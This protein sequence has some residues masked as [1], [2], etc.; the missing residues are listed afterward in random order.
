[1]S[2]GSLEIGSR[3]DACLAQA[4]AANPALTDVA[5]VIAACAEAAVDVSEVIGRGAL[6][7]GD[8]AAQGEQNSD[9]D[10]QKA[11]DVLAHERFTEA[12]R[13]APVAEVA[14]EEAA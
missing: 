4:V 2:L 12:L 5:A 3:L 6:G 9:G 1:M 10:V 13:G 8:L 11:L 7:G 14:S